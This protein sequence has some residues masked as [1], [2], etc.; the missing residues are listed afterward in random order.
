MGLD[1]WPTRRNQVPGERDRGGLTAGCVIPPARHGDPLSLAGAGVVLQ[2]AAGGLHGAPIDAGVKQAVLIEEG[3]VHFALT[4]GEAGV[5]VGDQAA[6]LLHLGEP[7]HLGA[8]RAAVSAANLAEGVSLHPA[9]PKLVDAGSK[10]T[11]GHLQIIFGVAVIAA[12]QAHCAVLHAPGDRDRQEAL[13]VIHDLEAEL[14]LHHHVEAKGK[15]IYFPMSQLQG[16][17]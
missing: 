7:F 11:H 2:P 13:P 1:S 15:D 10:Q 17:I 8:G 5:L 4:L 12:A 6:Q 9:L 14:R 3:G 16:Q